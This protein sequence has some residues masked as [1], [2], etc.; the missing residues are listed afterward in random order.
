LRQQQLYQPP[1]AYEPFSHA[2]AFRPMGVAVPKQAAPY[3]GGLITNHHFVDKSIANKVVSGSFFDISLLSPIE[4]Y[5]ASY[6]GAS[7]APLEG[8]VVSIEN[9]QFVATPRSAKRAVVNTL[10]LFV[11]AWRITLEVVASHMAGLAAALLDPRAATLYLPFPSDTIDRAKRYCD[12]LQ[13]L[14]TQARSD[15]VALEYDRWHRMNKGVWF[16]PGWEELD[17]KQSMLMIVQ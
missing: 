2:P 4:H 16:Q 9:G 5:H 14:G 8:S 1:T 17:S 13:E 6:A 7:A 11:G 15:A 10:S 12:N 3:L